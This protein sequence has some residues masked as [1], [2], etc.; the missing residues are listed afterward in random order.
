MSKRLGSERGSQMVELALLLPFLVV[1]MLGSTDFARAAYYAITLSH[2]AR[3]G[4]QYATQSGAHSIN[5]AGI[6]A[7][8]QM[9]AQNI[10][11]ISVVSG[12]FCQC[13]GSTVQVSCTVGTC[14]GDAAKLSFA[15]VTASRT[16]E[17]IAPYPAVPS[18]IDMSRTAVMRIQ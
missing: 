16:F 6:Q 4:A 17:T 3:A 13:P 1:L 12:T 9:E 7:A 18:S 5:T 14:T 2:A 10:G 15:T 11:S 8:A